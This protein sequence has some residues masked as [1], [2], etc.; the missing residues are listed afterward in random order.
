MTSKLI[1]AL[2]SQL[3]VVM[4]SKLYTIKFKDRIGLGSGSISI[5]F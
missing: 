3:G 2:V 4:G 1:T 5:H